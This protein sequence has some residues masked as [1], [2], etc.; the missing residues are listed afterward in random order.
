[1]SKNLLVFFCN[2]FCRFSVHL[3]KLLRRPKNVSNLKY[4]K[5]EKTTILFR[6]WTINVV[7]WTCMH[8]RRFYC[9]W[10]VIYLTIKRIYYY[11]YYRR[12]RRLLLQSFYITCTCAVC[13]RT[14]RITRVE[15]GIYIVKPR[16]I[17]MSPVVLPNLTGLSIFYLV[18]V[19]Y[20]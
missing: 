9:F 11:S 8:S 2:F 17:R 1:M 5:Y 14:A 13:I 12:W 6:F 19:L 20:R 10:N 16:V 7:F 18:F 15:N 4:M 3:R